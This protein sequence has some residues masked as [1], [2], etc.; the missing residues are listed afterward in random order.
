MALR[1]LLLFRADRDLPV[2][3]QLQKMKNGIA[4]GDPDAILSPLFDLILLPQ[5]DFI[6]ICCVSAQF[7]PF[8]F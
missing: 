6:S 3:V 7:L 8:A 5:I 4:D 2:P 1:A